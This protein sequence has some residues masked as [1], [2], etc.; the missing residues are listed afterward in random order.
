MDFNFPRFS[1]E[2]MTDD[3]AAFRDAALALVAKLE[4][5]R[6]VSGVYVLRLGAGVVYVGQSGCVTLRVAQH[7]FAWDSAQMVFVRGLPRRLI[8]ESVLIAHLKPTRNV[9]LGY[10][11]NAALA[12][13]LRDSR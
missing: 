5:V 4:P 8:A 2:A 1:H 13:N 10:A 6:P 11:P 7:R 12:A 9:D 3:L